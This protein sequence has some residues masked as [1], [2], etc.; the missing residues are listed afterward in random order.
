M[1]VGCFLAVF[2]LICTMMACRK[3]KVSPLPPEVKSCD[4]I[5][6]QGQT[7]IQEQSSGSYYQYDAE[8]NLLVWYY[9][10]NSIE[11]TYTLSY[12]NAEL[13]SVHFKDHK[14]D[15][16]ITSL[17]SLGVNSN[18]WVYNY[19]DSEGEIGIDSLELSLTG[20][21]LNLYDNDNGVTNYYYNPSDQL[22]SIV[23]NAKEQKWLFTYSNGK[24]VS[25]YYYLNEW[26]MGKV[27]FNYDQYGR[28]IKIDLG[29]FL[30]Q[31][32]EQV[33]FIYN[34]QG[35]LDSSIYSMGGGWFEIPYDQCQCGN[36]PIP[37]LDPID[38]FVNP[39]NFLSGGNKFGAPTYY[40]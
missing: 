15:K 29:P 35:E 24:L 12:E 4:S 13:Y 19:S 30:M 9:K 16:S 3:D 2:S 38:V 22:D 34:L 18:V 26:S 33:K 31:D 20:K 36:G 28:L 10:T 8:G 5:Y 1:K 37:I 23:D 14:N 40:Y 32:S 25:Y 39:M 17:I 11:E 6:M 21:V 7:I 27:F